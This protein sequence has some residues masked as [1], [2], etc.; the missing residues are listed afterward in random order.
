MVPNLP[1]QIRVL[2]DTI[3]S[4]HPVELFQ[5]SQGKSS[6]EIRTRKV[7]S[8]A[9]PRPN[10]NNRTQKTTLYSKWRK[11]WGEKLTN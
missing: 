10:K 7:T 2:V 1:I 3:M 5:L 11:Q 6:T 8:F 4:Q 9:I